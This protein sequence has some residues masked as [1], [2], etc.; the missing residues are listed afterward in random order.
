MKK[1]ESFQSQ[2][3]TIKTFTVSGSLTGTCVLSDEPDLPGPEPDPEPD[4]LPT[5]VYP[6]QVKKITFKIDNIAFV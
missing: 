3:E 1:W 4:D 6:S 2:F 5:S